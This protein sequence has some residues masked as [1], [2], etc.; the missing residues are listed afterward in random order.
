VIDETAQYLWLEINREES[1]NVDS[2][3]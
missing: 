2:N 3:D 1:A